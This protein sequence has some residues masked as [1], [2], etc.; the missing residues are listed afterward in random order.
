MVNSKTRKVT[1]TPKDHVKWAQCA[2]LGPKNCSSM[3][4]KLFWSFI[5]W[6]EYNQKLKVPSGKKKM[7][8]FFTKIHTKAASD[9]IKWNFAYVYANWIGDTQSLRKI[10]G[11]YL[12]FQLNSCNFYQTI[13]SSDMLHLDGYWENSTIGCVLSKA[14]LTLFS[15]TNSAQ[16]FLKTYN[17]ISPDFKNKFDFYDI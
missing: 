13:I 1:L 14:N 12:E 8:D 4:D 2:A 17:I 5:D 10:D 7:I 11:S 6:T 9:E 16:I 15:S 3:E